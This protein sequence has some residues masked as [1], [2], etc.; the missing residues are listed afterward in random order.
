MAFYEHT[1]IG[2]QDLSNKEVENLI[3][4]YSELINKYPPIDAVFPKGAICL[5]HGNIIHGSHPNLSKDS[6]RNQYSM[7]YL[8]KGVE[9]PSKGS[10]SKKIRTPLY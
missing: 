4:K 6:D 3:T 1:F 9:F 10:N 5:M 8:N 2:K 7:C